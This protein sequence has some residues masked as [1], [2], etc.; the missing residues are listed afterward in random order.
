[1]RVGPAE[2]VFT[3]RA[4]GD[5]G[6]AGRWVAVDEVDGDVEARRR[7][8][9][10]RPWSWLR[11]VHG[12]DVVVV[13]APGGGAGQPGDALVTTA[14]GTALAVLTADCGPVALVSDEGVVGAVHAGWRGV[15]AGVIER[16]VAAMRDLGA[17]RVRAALGPCIHP[18][19]YEFVAVELDRLA[20]ALGEGVRGTTAAGRPAFDLPAA[21]ASVLERAGAEL[22]YVDPVCTACSPVHF[23][24]R[25]RGELERQA[26]AVW[27]P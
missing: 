16:A 27:M 13:D 25:A 7:A 21:V 15:Q 18:E 19:C 20:A 26:V 9:V 24:H 2:V 23:S 4:E 3:G 17:G 8:V 11:Q 6:H 22:V 12:T 10:D 5:L 1:L 14:A